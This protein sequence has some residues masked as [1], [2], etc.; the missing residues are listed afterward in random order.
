MSEQIE[1]SGHSASSYTSP[2]ESYVAYP[3]TSDET[4]QVWKTKPKQGLESLVAG[5]AIVDNLTT[6][7]KEETLR[8]IRVFYFNRVTGN[9]LSVEEV[10]L[11]EMSKKAVQHSEGENQ[12]N[13]DE[14]TSTKTSAEARVLTF[15]E[16]QDLIESGKVDEIPNNK[17]IPEGL[18]V[19]NSSVSI[20]DK[21]LILQYI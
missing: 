6:E 14:A 18:N 16:L 7:E 21:D 12:R 2:L 4:Y 15:A 13:E 9:T 8:R 20:A 11:Y 1:E 19:S 5:G 3:F 17:V 10:R